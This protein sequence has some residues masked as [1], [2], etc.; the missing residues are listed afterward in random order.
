MSAAVEAEEQWGK[1]LLFISICKNIRLEIVQA[2]GIVD[3][4]YKALQYVYRIALRFFRALN[5][6]DF[7]FYILFFVCLLI[8]NLKTG[9]LNTSD[10]LKKKI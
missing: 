1:T 7:Y 3:S 6:I 4:F 10:E 2:V 5:K 8:H 9:A